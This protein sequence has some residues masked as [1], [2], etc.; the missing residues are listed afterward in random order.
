[1]ASLTTNDLRITNAK[2]FVNYLKTGDPSYMFIGRP[3][4]W[5][6]DINTV[7]P[8]VT[9]GD[10][11]PPYPENNWKDYYT[12]WNHMLGMNKIEDNEIHHM[13]PRITWTSGAVYDMYRHDYSEYLT[14]FTNAKNLYNAKF[15]VI[16]QNNNVYAC[17]DNNYITPS[18]V[19][20]L[21]DFDEPF[22]TSDGISVVETVPD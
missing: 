7:K 6:S 12:I 9:A 17:L 5:E 15:V 4:P 11:S 18:T 8:R 14:S 2:N 21:S 16:S 3:I 13:I 1:M 10:M 20:P 22:Y 19:E